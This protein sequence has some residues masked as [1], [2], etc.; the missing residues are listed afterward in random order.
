MKNDGDTPIEIGSTQHDEMCNFY[1][2]YYTEQ[3]DGRP[4]EDFCLYPGHPDGNWESFQDADLN[5]RAIPSNINE[6]P[7]PPP[8]AMMMNH[9]GMNH[10][11]SS[12][13]GSIM[14]MNHDGGDHDDSMPMMNHKI[15][16]EKNFKVPDHHVMS[17][18]MIDDPQYQVN[19]YQM[20]DEY[21]TSNERT[22]YDYDPD[23]YGHNAYEDQ[24]QQNQVQNWGLLA[25]FGKK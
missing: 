13:D 9:H 4:M 5:L 7:P 10:H 8:G 12:H 2:Y 6:V 1:I 11:Q 17:E 3:E 15:E 25:A 23:P 14:M 19:D 22:A 24:Q 20:V 21:P 18:P 16:N